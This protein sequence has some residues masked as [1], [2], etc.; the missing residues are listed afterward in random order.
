[1]A[2]WLE[3]QEALTKDLFHRWW[4]KMSVSGL[5]PVHAYGSLWSRDLMSPKLLIDG[6]DNAAQS[7]WE[8]LNREGRVL[9]LRSP[10]TGSKVLVLGVEHS[11]DS[12]NCV[13]I[14]SIIQSLR[15]DAVAIELDIG[16]HSKESLR[17]LATTVRSSLISSIDINSYT[18]FHAGLN[19]ASSVGSRVWLIDREDAEGRYL[20]S[21]KPSE[22]AIH[23]L[24]NVVKNI[25]PNHRDWSPDLFPSWSRHIVQERDAN[26][27]LAMRN[28]PGKVVVGIVG[29]VRPRNVD[30]DSRRK[31]HIEGIE[32]MWN[33][34]QEQVLSLL[35][36]TPAPS[37]EAVNIGY[38]K[39]QAVYGLMMSPFLFGLKAVYVKGSRVI[40]ER[41]CFHTSVYDKILFAN[42]QMKTFVLLTCIVTALAG[43]LNLINDGGFYPFVVHEPETNITKPWPILMFLHG[44]GCISDDGNWVDRAQWDGVGTLLNQWNSGNRG[45]KQ[46]MVANQFLTVIPVARKTYNNKDAGDQWLS[47]HLIEVLNKVKSRYSVD[48][49]RLYVTGYSMG[50]FGTWRFNIQ[51]PE[52]V[53]ASVASAG[54]P[55]DGQNS[56][57]THVKNVAD[58]PFHL[59][60]SEADTIIEFPKCKRAAGY[61]NNMNNRQ[62][63]VT[64]YPASMGVQHGDNS[65]EKGMGHLPFTADVFRWLL[66]KNLNRT[67]IPT[68]SPS[69]D[70]VPT[71][72]PSPDPIP[73][74]SGGKQEWEMCS[75]SSE[76]ANHCCSKQ[77][78]GD[79]LYKC[80]PNSDQCISS[81]SG[82]KGLW[83]MCSASSECANHCCS[84]QYSGD[85][86]YK[87]TP[88]SQQC[89]IRGHT[90]G[91]TLATF[92]LMSLSHIEQ[93]NETEALPES[94]ELELVQEE[95]DPSPSIISPRTS[96]KHLYA[97]NSEVQATPETEEEDIRYSDDNWIHRRYPKKQKKK[98]KDKMSK[99][100]LRWLPVAFVL[101]IVSWSYYV[102]VF[103]LT[104]PCIYYG[105]VFWIQPA[106]AN[107]TAAATVV[108]EVERAVQ[109]PSPTYDGPLVHPPPPSAA[110]I[111]LRIFLLIFFHFFF[112]L[113]LA[114]YYRVVMTDAG[115]VPR[116]F[117]PSRAA[118]RK[119][120]GEGSRQCVKCQNYK[121]DRTHHCSAC[122]KCHHCPWV[123]NC[124]GWN[125]HKFF[126]LF[127]LYIALTG[128]FIV[129]TSFSWLLNNLGTISTH[130]RSFQIPALFIAMCIFSFG[131][132]IFAGTHVRL[133]LVNQTTIETFEKRRRRL[134][135]R[136]GPEGEQYEVESVRE[137]KDYN[138]YDVGAW[139]NWTSVF[140]TNPLLW[141]LPVTTNRGDGMF[142]ETR[143]KVQT[144][145]EQE[146]NRLLATV[147][148]NEEYT[149]GNLYAR[150]DRSRHR[151]IEDGCALSSNPENNTLLASSIEDG[152]SV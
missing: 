90:L 57:D 79:G 21:V 66:T 75:D 33:T 37:E 116:S 131:M 28:I 38:W 94:V 14:E 36:Q 4:G 74:E 56:D 142:F 86:Q 3:K 110:Y 39:Q 141:F 132:A 81:N 48:S 22:L 43:P 92:T 45:D 130:G 149:Q 123:N 103:E 85:G 5:E 34:P 31:G 105:E 17:D 147:S 127:L 82:S 15:P 67:V 98:K 54:F 35:P 11:G 129:V 108:H 87:C 51:H 29:W 44:R 120:D 152:R 18:E 138:V 2:T 25:S 133:L 40:A 47:D 1:M 61:L 68:D 106:S 78:S 118:E 83:E 60:C 73:T 65:N 148:Q 119:S 143:E 107:S 137:T 144:A 55:Y 63:I 100:C 10:E 125:N 23:S 136:Q 69:P 16:R 42:K 128:I 71:E 88:D 113:L 27:T 122:Q 111:A 59:F 13:A 80:T 53:A 109:S 7:H 91:P 32:K 76:C 26:M 64:I 6:G 41:P 9:T 101:A 95:E 117:E 104:I 49:N 114:S 126:F 93:K 139:K 112:V 89:L 62:D 145:E 150:V 102:Y 96:N 46:T 24:Q 151:S 115:S 70:P 50:A 140:G 84:K 12:D 58:T 146:R 135:R 134:R 19:G 99:L 77:Y 8:K 30:E 124:V 121:P 97:S 52:L 72:S 20:A